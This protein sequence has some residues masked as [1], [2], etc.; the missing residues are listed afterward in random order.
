MLRRVE[1]GLIDRLP[2]EVRAILTAEDTAQLLGG[3]RQLQLSD[4]LVIQERVVRRPGLDHAEGDRCRLAVDLYYSGPGALLGEHLL[5]PVAFAWGVRV[6]HPLEE[7]AGTRQPQATQQVLEHLLRLLLSL[8]NR[9]RSVLRAQEPAQV[10]RLAEGQLTPVVTV[11]HAPWPTV[12]HLSEL[13]VGFTA[14]QHL[15]VD[16]LSGIAQL[17]ERAPDR[18]PH[19]A[20]D[21]LHEKVDE[22]HPSQR[23]G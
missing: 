4:V 8:V 6:Q 20:W 22:G 5:N 23:L 18:D 21:R 19:V 12:A 14:V 16:A 2:V 1:R 3:V 17:G 13:Y 11:D 10:L 9:K 15:Q 7:L